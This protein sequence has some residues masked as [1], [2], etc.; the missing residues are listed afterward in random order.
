MNSNF[1]ILPAIDIKDGQCVRLLKGDFDKQTAY[2]NDPVAQAK[3][4]DTQGAKYLHVVDLDGALEG[5]PRNFDL[6]KKIVKQTN[7][8]VEVSGGIRTFEDI[9]RY[10]A[11]NPWQIILGSVAVFNLNF[12]SDVI[13]KYSSEKFSIALD[14]KDGFAASRGWVEKSDITIADLAKQLNEIGIKRVIFTDVGRDGTLTGVNLEKT[15][16]MKT[17]FSGQVIASGGVSTVEDVSQL[18]EA[19]VDG[20]IIGK[21][22]YENKIDLKELL[23][24]QKI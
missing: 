20:T 10:L 4:F 22:L 7:C 6:I 1:Q 18:K 8:N 19:G 5:N 16:E 3:Y 14:S 23:S 9:E 13:K 12:V 21:A 15:L 2:N 11:I 24:L 17:I